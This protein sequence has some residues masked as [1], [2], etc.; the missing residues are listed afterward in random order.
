MVL[1][2]VNV[3]IMY[4]YIVMYSAF[5]SRSD[6]TQ[7]AAHTQH[8]NDGLDNLCSGIHV[9]PIENAESLINDIGLY[10]VSLS[11]VMRIWANKK[12]RHR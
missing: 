9:G 5:T 1:G 2:P 6:T 10:A 12:T 8:N 7:L 4:S 3:N 11:Q